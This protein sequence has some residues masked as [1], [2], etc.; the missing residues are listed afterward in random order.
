[1]SGGLDSAALAWLYRPDLCVTVDYG[2]RPA[3]GERVASAALCK[4]MG[5]HHLVLSIDHSSIGSGNMSDV[6][7]IPDAQAPEFWPYRNQCLITLAAM[8]LVGRGLRELM[9]GI[10]A[11]DVHA[12]G[13]QAFVDAMDALLALQEGAVRLTAPGLLM[14]G[15]ELLRNSGFP[16]DLI[17]LTFSCHT[18]QY[19][20]GQC[21]GCDKHRETVQEVYKGGQ[22]SSVGGGA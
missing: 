11:T 6:A 7:A 17:G 5:L 12:D 2:Q 9:I 22:Q 16:H 8:A 3:Q 4:Q 21:G 14:T 1:M 18:H 10:V 13:S 15:A 20:C 19:A